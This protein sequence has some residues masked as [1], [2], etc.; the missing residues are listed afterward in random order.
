MP[1]K[2]GIQ[3]LPRAKV[4]ISENCGEL[5]EIIVINDHSSDGTGNFLQSWAAEDHRVRAIDNSG[6]G[7]V[8]ALNLGLLSA[9]HNWVARFDVDDIYVPSRISR[10]ISAITSESVAIFSDY[11]LSTSIGKNLGTIPSGVDSDVVAIS[12]Y[13]SQRTPH[14]SVLFSKSHVIEVGGYRASDFPAEDLSLWLRLAR[15]GEL[16][17]IPEAFLNYQI[18]PNS[19]TSLNQGKM[20]S[21][22]LD[23]LKEFPIASKYD[24]S[25]S[26]RW[27]SIF[28]DYA[29]YPQVGL[30]RILLCL[31]FANLA[32]GRGQNFSDLSTLFR[33]LAFLIA[34]PSTYVGLFQALR[35]V[36]GKRWLLINN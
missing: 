21:K 29:S 27:K 3:F 13:K 28:R 34:R 15:V 24:V 16:I 17:S 4:M 22:R 33:M 6:S 7:L 20:V 25:I 26:I 1:V 36:A 35:L 31:D 9:Q 11:S 23:L 30:R 8:D 2:N 32:F 18:N 19:V 10:Q 12:L 14:P 5:D